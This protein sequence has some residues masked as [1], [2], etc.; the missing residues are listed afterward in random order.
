MSS[1]SSTWSLSCIRLLL[2]TYFPVC[3]NE[4]RGSFIHVSTNSC[5]VQYVVFVLCSMNDRIAHADTKTPNNVETPI[6][7]ILL[8]SVLN[9][10][11]RFTFHI[12]CI[13]GACSVGVELVVEFKIMKFSH[14]SLEPFAFDFCLASSFNWN[15][16]QICLFR[17]KIKATPLILP[18]Q[19]NR[20]NVNWTSHFALIFTHV[21]QYSVP[22]D[23]LR[24][25]HSI[26]HWISL[27]RAEKWRK[28]EFFRAFIIGQG[29]MNNRATLNDKVISLIVTFI[30]LNWKIWAFSTLTCED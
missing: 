15:Q 22:G 10:M 5:W 13:N 4:W 8:F 9:C 30:I 21:A 26:E 20:Y 18:E 1:S 12:A 2:D 6:N 11:N 24:I 14:H 17:R 28:F 19:N 25:F 27:H 3:L 7:S 29:D 16:K 23:S